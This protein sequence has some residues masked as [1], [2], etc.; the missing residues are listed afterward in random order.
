MEVMNITDLVLVERNTL[1]CV[2]DIKT[3]R[4]NLREH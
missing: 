3:V 4:I 2:H 1:K